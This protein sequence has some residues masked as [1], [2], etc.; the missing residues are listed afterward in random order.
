MNAAEKLRQREC[1]AYH[2]A[3][4]A[5]IA[6]A[7]GVRVEYILMVRCGDAAAHVS[8][9]PWQKLGVRKLRIRAIVYYAGM[10]AERVAGFRCTK[11]RKR[12]RSSDQ[13]CIGSIVR[14]MNLLEA[15]MP[16]RHNKDGTLKISFARTNAALKLCDPIKRESE[17]LVTQHWRDIERLARVLR[18]RDFLGA[19]EIERLLGTERK[20]NADDERSAYHEAGHAVVGYQFG[21][22]LRRGGVRIGADAA[23]HH[24]TPE[25]LYTERSRVMVALAGWVADAKFL[26][27][28]SLV[29]YDEILDAVKHLPSDTSWDPFAIAAEVLKADPLINRRA[30]RAWVRRYERETVALI[31]EPRVWSAVERVADALVRRRQLSNAAAVRL[32]G[33]S[34]FDGVDSKEGAKAWII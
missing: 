4:H 26:G 22:Y 30:A 10:V 12:A 3:G 2:E 7:L 15:G 27:V 18:R 21:W 1:L 28:K 31:N 6:H 29:A 32:L 17:V 5:V 11:K 33:R 9:P 20:A 14:R 13:G 34:F 24:R 16:I 23:T 8:S 19:A 25:G